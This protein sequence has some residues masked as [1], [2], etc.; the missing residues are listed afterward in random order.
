MSTEEEEKLDK[1]RAA[2]AATLRRSAKMVTPEPPIYDEVYQRG[3]EWLESG[4]GDK[5]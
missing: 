1:L 2:L 5:F 3:I 4:D